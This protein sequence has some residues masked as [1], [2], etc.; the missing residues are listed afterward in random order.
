MNILLFTD[1]LRQ[2]DTTKQKDAKI[3]AADTNNGFVQ[4]HHDAVMLLPL[5][6]R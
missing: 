2:N 1:K 3:V 6:T 5:V 4:C